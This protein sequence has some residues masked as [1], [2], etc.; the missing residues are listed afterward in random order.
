MSKWKI[1]PLKG[2][3]SEVLSQAYNSLDPNAW[4]VM[5]HTDEFEMI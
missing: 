5:E 2:S 3:G 1:K 4:D